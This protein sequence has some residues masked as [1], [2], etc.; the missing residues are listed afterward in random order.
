MRIDPH[1][2]LRGGNQ[3]HKE[4]ISHAFE[5]AESQGVDVL[6]DMAA[7]TDSPTI[8]LNGV[9]ERLALVPEKYRRGYF[10][11]LGLTS[12]IEQIEEAVTGFQAYKEVIGLKLF[13]GKSV[14]DLA[15]VSVHEQ[16]LVYET[17]VREGYPG[18]LA[19]HCEKESLLKPELW[20]PRNP[21]SHS[22]ARPKEAEIE[23]IKDQISLVKE[24]DFAGTLHICHISCPESV[25]LVD[26]ARKQGMRITCG[27][28]P[29][30]LLYTQEMQQG[31]GGLIYK[32]NPP[33]REMADVEALRYC[34]LR[35]EID[36]IETDHAPHAVGEKIFPP[37]YLS[38][39]SSLYL[40]QELVEDFLPKFGISKSRI[41][42]MTYWNIV[43]VFGDKLKA[44]R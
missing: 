25:E 37:Y 12:K 16:R 5:V 19:V 8:S 15:V 13:A 36:W 43:R 7:N 18:V 24:T 38:G 22:R 34:V 14:G 28:T 44:I 9:D 10:L 4:T 41:D 23:S 30:H 31:S 39:F 40:Y 20:D 26:A 33:L 3:S 6:F 27:V 42:E 2:H 17:L 11:W 29:H 1:A 35:G 21:I 32:T